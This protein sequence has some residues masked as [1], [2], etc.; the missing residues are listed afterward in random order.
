MSYDAMRLEVLAELSQKIDAESVKV[1]LQILDT[2]AD[3]YEISKR[4]TALSIPGSIPEVVKQYISS[5]AVENVSINTL[6][7]YKSTMLN[8]FAAVRKPYTDVTANDIRVF[9]YK[10]KQERKVKDSTLETIRVTINGFFT[11]CVEEE[12]LTKNPCRK[13]ST[14]KAQ[15]PTRHAMTMLELEKM[16]QL[17]KTPQEKATVDFLYSTGCRVQ[18]MCDVKRSD[19]NWIERTVTIQRGKGGKSRVTYLNPEAIISLQLYMNSRNDDC[20]YLFRCDRFAH[21]M[22]RGS[23][24]AELDRIT[25]R[26]PGFFTT[27]ITPHVFRHTAATTALRNGMPIEQVQRFLG[28]SKISTTLIYAQTDDSMVKTMHQRC[29]S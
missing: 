25:D 1:V 19:V 27:R 9:L 6:K 17:C 11:W 2:V 10:Y 8:F 23:V 18:E 21:K 12:L 15:P 5:R 26:A 20:E 4:E 14:I 29:V 3:R 13:V 24:E 16:R 28:H 22:S 7:Y